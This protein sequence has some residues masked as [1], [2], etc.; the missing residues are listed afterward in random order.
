VAL[1]AASDI[2]ERFAMAKNYQFRH[3]DNPLKKA[4]PRRMP[5]SVCHRGRTYRRGRWG[6]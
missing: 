2:P 1:L 3:R 6:R 4:V 5:S